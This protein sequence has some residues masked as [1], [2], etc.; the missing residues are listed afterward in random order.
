MQNT[1]AVYMIMPVCGTIKSS[2]ICVHTRNEKM[3][4]VVHEE[5]FTLAIIT[6]TI[7][8]SESAP[9]VSF[10]FDP[11]SHNGN[12][13]RKNIV[14]FRG[15]VSCFGFFASFMKIGNIHTNGA[16]AKM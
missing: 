10:F 16:L 7:V 4:Q 3:N 1:Q 12:S 9:C 5:K 15:S 6:T 2:A 11:S 8:K 13:I 14:M